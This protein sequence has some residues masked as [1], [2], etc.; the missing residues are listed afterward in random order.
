ME[1]AIDDFPVDGNSSVEAVIAFEW[2]LHAVSP[3]RVI[4]TVKQWTR[5][6]FV[7]V[8]S[9]E[10]VGDRA[11]VDADVDIFSI[12]FDSDVV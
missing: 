6:Q 3:E 2:F 7:K 12:Y 10:D 4:G 8:V 11:R 5:G 1:G 9:G